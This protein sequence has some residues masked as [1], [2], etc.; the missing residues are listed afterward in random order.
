MNAAWKRGE[1]ETSEAETSERKIKRYA[2]RL[3][4]T[5][6]LKEGEIWLICT[7]QELLSHRNSRAK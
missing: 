1:G 3:F 7:L 2:C 5:S 6:S 4:G